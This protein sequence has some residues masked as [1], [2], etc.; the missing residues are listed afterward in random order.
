MTRKSHPDPVGGIGGM[1]RNIRAAPYQ[2]WL[3]VLILPEKKAGALV[4]AGE[5]KRRFGIEVTAR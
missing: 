5:Y 3:S 2:W 4:S 1:L